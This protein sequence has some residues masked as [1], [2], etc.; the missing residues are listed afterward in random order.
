LVVSEFPYDGR[1]D[2]GIVAGVLGVSRWWVEQQARRDQIPHVR[3]GRNVRYSLPRVREW[4][5][6][7][8]QG[9][10]KWSLGAPSMSASLTALR[11]SGVPD[12]TETSQAR[13]RSI[14]TSTAS[15]DV[16]NA[17]L[18]TDLASGQALSMDDHNLMNVTAPSGLTSKLPL[19]VFSATVIPRVV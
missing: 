10:S 16:S 4:A 2:A 6:A 12:A 8:E 9:G 15:T 14:N 13:R 1:L 18:S 11:C 3:F 5:E 17:E 19:S 7:K